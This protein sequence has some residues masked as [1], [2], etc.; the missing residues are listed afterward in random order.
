MKMKLFFTSVVFFILG[1]SGFAQAPN[2]AEPPF[3]P[4]EKLKF[5]LKWTVIKAGEA[6]LEVLPIETVNGVSAYHFVMT[7]ESTP[8]IDVFYKIRDRIDAYTDVSMTHSILY[9]KKQ[10]EGSTHRDEIVQF[11]WEKNIVQYSNF[12]KKREPLELKPGAFDPLSVFY[13]SRFFDMKENMVIERP[14]TDGKK[15]VMGRAKVVRKEKIK[16][17]EK[18]YDSWLLEPELKDIG[19]VFEKSKNAKIRLWVSADKR[20][21][22][23]RIE[24]KVIVG[25]FVGELISESF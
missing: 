15:C 2:P 11:D 22:P 18:T 19:G 17:G 14:V 6:T 23:L 10:L 24:S 21:I 16:I 13:Y 3:H 1:T 5:E 7:A 8:F 12:G 20:R 25:S 4:G 9:K